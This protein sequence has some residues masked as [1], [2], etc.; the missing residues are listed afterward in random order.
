M[1]WEV[2]IHPRDRTYGSGT[3]VSY[4][5]E[6]RPKH[7]IDDGIITV[8]GDRDQPLVLANAGDM[9]VMVINKQTGDATRIT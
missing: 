5:Q 7:I 1:S 8:T 4:E 3:T 2:V 9:A 6:E